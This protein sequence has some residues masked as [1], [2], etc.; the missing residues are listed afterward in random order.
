[1]SVPQVAHMDLQWF[2]EQ[3]KSPKLLDEVKVEYTNYAGKLN[4][5]I[6]LTADEKKDVCANNGN[7]FC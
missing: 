6:H 7:S 3:L 1:M 5:E 4:E 2:A